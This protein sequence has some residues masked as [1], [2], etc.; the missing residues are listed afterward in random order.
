MRK[1]SKNTKKLQKGSFEERLEQVVGEYR[2]AKQVLDSL[3]PD[4]AD[5]AMQQSKCDKLFA[6]AERFINKQQ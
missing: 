2:Q 1:T 3:E 6:I 4:D 5:F